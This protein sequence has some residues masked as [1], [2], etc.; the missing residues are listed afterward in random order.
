M[1]PQRGRQKIFDA[2]MDLFES[3]GYFATTVEQITTEAGVS[4]GLVYN[5]FSSKEQ[6]LVA[7]LEHATA[8][9]ASVAEPRSTDESLEASVV[10]LVD[11][12]FDF[13]QTH[14][15]FLKLQLT[16]MLMPELREIVAGPQHERAELLLSV[17]RATFERARL[18]H[19]K[20]KA[21]V[22][23]ALLDGVALHYLCVYD[24][25][26]L[27]AMRAHVVRSALGICETTPAHNG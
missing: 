4:K 25:Y 1:R 20:R 21:R 9:M 6:L 3:Q 7:L 18:P 17:T 19:P 16:L 5:Y 2:A 8:K 14:R 26:P 27:G 11:R 13:L 22:L 23:L 10:S 12:F 24:P 15:R